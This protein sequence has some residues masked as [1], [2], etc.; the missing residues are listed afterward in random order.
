MQDDRNDRGPGNAPA[1]EDAE[2]DVLG[3][4]ISAAG[5]RPEPPADA[6]EQ[7]LSAAHQAWLD[8]VRRRQHR[9]WSYAAAATIAVVGLSIA[10]LVELLP[11][12]GGPAIAS[13]DIVQGDVRIRTPED[14]NWRGIT[15]SDT[16]LA[17]GTRLRSTANGRIAL[18]LAGTASLRVDAGSEGSRATSSSAGLAS[19]TR[20]R[21]CWRATTCARSS[22]W[23][24]F[25]P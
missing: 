25:S 19:A 7:I 5:K 4:L 22:W 1:G 11:Q 16:R 14:A 20:P 9:R 17:A 18:T 3:A 21:P 2:R 23:M 8:S 12:S 6:H 15:Q 24:R 10:L 13:T